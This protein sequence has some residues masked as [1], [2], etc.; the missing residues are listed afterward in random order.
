MRLKRKGI[1]GL[2]ALLLLVAFVGLSMLSGCTQKEES[3][4]AETKQEEKNQ[5]QA[6]VI[7]LNVNLSAPET[8]MK[9]FQ[10]FAK[11][12][13]SRSGGRVKFNIFYS[14]SLV[15]VMEVPK[16]LSS[17]VADISNL[18]PYLYPG[19]LPLNGSITGLPL[20]GI[21]STEAGSELYHQLFKKYPGMKAEFDKLGIKL[22]TGS[23]MAP[24]QLLN[25]TANKM[26][27]PANIKG[28]KIISGKP[29]FGELVVAAGGAPVSMPISDY[30]MSLERGVADA[31]ATTVNAAFAFGIA[32]LVKQAVIFGEE[33]GIYMDL[34]AFAMNQKSWDKLPADIQKIFEEELAKLY[35]AEIKKE[36]DLLAGFT[37]KLKASAN[38]TVLTPEEIEAWAKLAK[39]LHEKYINELEAKGLPG[40]A[41]YEDI[42]KFISEKK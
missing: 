27:L 7:E 25:V 6:E 12:V 3:K 26:S 5:E 33:T 40:K 29:V 8:V 41:M 39:P 1:S 38:Y 24:Q 42:M 37:E 14:N 28:K 4:Q 23:M 30:Y 31:V 9:P 21:P 15:P 32:P 17:G 35:V 20:L 11:T 16:A 13:E 10:E 22:L 2:L 34:Q 36:R 18:I 19:V